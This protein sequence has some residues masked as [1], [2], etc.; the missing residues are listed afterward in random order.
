MTRLL[1]V[2]A[3]AVCACAR[4][5]LVEDFTVPPQ[6]SKP[7]TYWFWTNTLTDRE[8]MREEL[9]DMARLGFGGL[10]LTDSRGYWD[11][12]NHV[13]NPPATMR[14]GS[15]EWLDLIAF[16]V[17]EAARH[18]LRFS[19][20]VAASGGHLRGDVDAGADN[21]KFLMC[22]RYL[23]G[24]AFELP[25]I[26]HFRDVAVFAVRTAAPAVKSAWRNA[27]DGFYSMAASSGRRADGDA[28]LATTPALEVRELTDAAA[29]ARLGANW[30]VLRFG[31]GT[32]KG[33]EV[34][35]D[36]LDR[37]AVRRHLERVVGKLI[38][39]VPDLTGRDRTFAYLYNV[40]WEGAMPTWSATFERDFAASEGYAL[41]PLL[42]ALA[43]FTLAAKKTPDLMRDFRH[44]RGLMMRD[45]L[46]G[47]VHDW[48]H[49]HG[50]GAFSES[51]GPWSR[52]PQT[53]GEC[54]Q[55]GF[56]AANDFPQ[57][58]FWPVQ[59]AATAEQGGHANANGRYI[60]KG[61]VSAAHAYDRPYASI[62]AF[63]H[64]HHH[65]SVDPAF[66][67]P[68]GD[69]AFADGINL[70]VWHTYTTSPKKYG[71]PGLEYF[72]GSH[73]NRNVTW[74]DDFPPMVTY[75]ARCQTLLQRGQPVTDVAVLVG[76]RAYTH[77]GAS[78]NGRFRNRVSDEMPLE[79]PR[80]YA[81]DAVNDEAL[82]RNP[83]LLARYRV[84]HD[85][86]PADRR[87]GTVDVKDLPPDVAEAGSYTWCHRRDG[88]AEWY[89]LAG[90]GPVAPVFRAAAPAVEIW[91]AVTGRRT[92]AQ[93][94]RVGEGRTRVTLDLPVGGSCFVV[95]LPQATAEAVARPATEPVAVKG[96][97]NVSFAYHPGLT[98]APPAPIALDAL[99]EFTTR[100]DLRHFAGTATYVTT[101][102]LP[103]T[104]PRPNTLALGT[105]LTGVAHVYVNGRDCGTV[106]CA[107][108]EA[109]VAA[110]LKPGANRIEIR[111]TNNWFNRLVGDCAL[112][113]AERVTRSVLRY[114]NVPRTNSKQHWKCKPTVYS[115]Y[116]SHD[117]L[118]KC[119]L[120]GP[121]ILR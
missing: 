88:T 117:P 119:G 41:R 54:D 23:P 49:K 75:L 4:A 36:V 107:P 106:W 80:G 14:W 25:A 82:A 96:P 52:N 19:L 61:I 104:G 51:G 26:P 83:K 57:G 28:D 47:E 60:V 92:P 48:A 95:F 72:A 24:E 35:I 112:P 53:F 16:G 102:D 85:A 101:V 29:G 113:E 67:K 70:F 3:F 1:L 6:A 118:Q 91:D 98:A 5:G 32:L 17:R 78:Q 121:V 73:I 109:D 30:T 43:G 90:E 40:S 33:Q 111:Y 31:A 120:L 42:P 77:W 20:N 68:V 45:H 27:G 22:R 62:E 58:E 110:A 55:M 11:D 34:D 15:D 69:Q 39:R 81:Y 116:S 103:A 71:T 21:P 89:F 108:W 56:L 93:A 46:Y 50:M 10:M 114:W 44:A 79:I 18:N 115:G 100:E 99:V 2:S 65:W 13:R 105:V 64:M 7:W 66:L 86:R 74:H 97:W 12:E 87:R 9:A 38:A 63:T 8:T 84:V 37:L 94:A 76:D 59:G